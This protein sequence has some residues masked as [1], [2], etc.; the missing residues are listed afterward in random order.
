[1]K[2]KIKVLISVCLLG[3][4][5]K[6]FGGNNFILEFVILLEKYNVDIVKVCFECFVG[7]FI[8]RVLLEIKEIKVFSKDGRDIIEEFLFGVEKIFKIVKEN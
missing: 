5:V 8:L 1:M 7:L 6:Y 3:D 4:N 2:K